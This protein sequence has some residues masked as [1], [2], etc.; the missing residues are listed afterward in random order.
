M[1]GKI[2]F[3]TVFKH[4]SG[5]GSYVAIAKVTKVRPYALKADS[6]DISDHDST[7]R[8]REKTAGMLEAGAVSLDLNYDQDAA[9]HQ[10]L[11]STLGTTKNYR[12]AFPGS[13]TATFSG[14]IDGVTPELPHDNKMT[15]SVS[16]QISGVITW[17]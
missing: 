7:S 13:R 14:F 16:V 5:G 10:L 1:A 11:E 6:V 17:A 4:D 9:T 15:C 8:F 12:I 2:G 3:G